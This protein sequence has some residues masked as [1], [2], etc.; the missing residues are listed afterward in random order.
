VVHLA[1]WI[2]KLSESTEEWI[3]QNPG[4]RAG[5][6][7]PN[8]RIGRARD[9]FALWAVLERTP[10]FDLNHGPDRFSLLYFGAEGVATYRALYR[11]NRATPAAAAVIQP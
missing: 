4:V 9:S 6:G 10:E 3:P 7:N 8:V 11:S 1:A 2:E 5:G